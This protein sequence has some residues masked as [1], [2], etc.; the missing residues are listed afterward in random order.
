MRQLTEYPL[1]FYLVHTDMIILIEQQRKQRLL[2]R[3]WRPPDHPAEKMA[4]LSWK[5][6][7]CS[8]TLHHGHNKMEGQ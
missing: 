3:M 2:E 7:P 8:M 1:L 6:S 4:E 5:P